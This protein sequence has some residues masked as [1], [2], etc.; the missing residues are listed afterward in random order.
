MNSLT[1]ADP[2]AP[3]APAV[4]ER[5][6]QHLDRRQAEARA[7]PPRG[8]G[9]VPVAGRGGVRHQQPLRPPRR[10]RRGPSCAK[11][12]QHLPKQHLLLDREICFS[13]TLPPRFVDNLLLVF[14]AS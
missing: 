3:G 6:L 10:Q 7:G 2:K 8:F 12:R 4:P 14:S 11:T 13:F 5:P 9:A 1:F